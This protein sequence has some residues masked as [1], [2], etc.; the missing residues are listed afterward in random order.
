ML[1]GLFLFSSSLPKGQEA[2]L[3]VLVTW[4]NLQ[5]VSQLLLFNLTKFRHHVRTLVKHV[6]LG[7]SGKW[8]PTDVHVISTTSLMTVKSLFMHNVLLE[9]EC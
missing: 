3:F 2:C 6:Y 1:T 7:P 5:W 4:Q 8:N 9:T